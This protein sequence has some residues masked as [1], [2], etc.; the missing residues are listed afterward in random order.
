MRIWKD[1]IY[2]EII[3]LSLYEINCTCYKI[4]QSQTYAAVS[5]VMNTK[6][7]DLFIKRMKNRKQLHILCC[8]LSVYCGVL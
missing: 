1:I 2:I 4:V 8:I 6:S 7:P 3:F 5:T